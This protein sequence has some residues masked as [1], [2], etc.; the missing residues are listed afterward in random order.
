MPSL[1]FDEAWPWL[2]W[3]LAAAAVVTFV[4]GA[5]RGI[6]PAW[7]AISKFVATI[8]ALS[9]LPEDLE[10]QDAFREQVKITLAAQDVKIEQIHHEVNYNNGTSVKDG[11][12]R[13]EKKVD[14]AIAELGVIRDDQKIASDAAARAVTAATEAVTEAQNAARLAKDAL[15][16]STKDKT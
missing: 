7:R 4:V 9:A 16:R 3:I 14:G 12:T 11:I 8:N 10:K 2:Q 15:E 6:P 1:N 5:I 13:V